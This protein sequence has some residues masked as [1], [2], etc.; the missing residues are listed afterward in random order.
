MGQVLSSY[1][2]FWKKPSRIGGSEDKVS[3]TGFWIPGG[4]SIKNRCEDAYQFLRKNS[5]ERARSQN[6]KGGWPSPQW[7]VNPVH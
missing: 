3:R 4:L 6:P 5:P 1:P 2:Y 7:L